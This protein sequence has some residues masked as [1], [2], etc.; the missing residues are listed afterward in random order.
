MLAGMADWRL[1]LE[2]EPRDMVCAEFEW[3]EVD[4]SSAE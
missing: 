4:V 2:E 3:S 1:G